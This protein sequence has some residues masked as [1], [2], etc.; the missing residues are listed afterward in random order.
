M[1]DINT[2]HTAPLDAGNLDR[3]LRALSMRLEENNAAPVE[4]VLCG[5]AA[6]ILSGM[7]ERVTRDVDIVALRDGSRLATPDP[8]PPELQKAAD[9]VAEDLG[10]SPQWLNNGPSSGDGG[11]FQMG[12]PEGFADR[13]HRRDYGRHL[14]VYFIDRRDQVH[15]K[16]YAAVDRGGYHIDDLR[17]LHPS[18]DELEAAAA[19][20]M[21]HD[22]SEGFRMLLKRLLGELGYEA[23]ACRI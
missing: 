19:W 20:A 15:F 11:L 6:L 9:E 4:L 16:L 10:L 13:L 2:T 12:L 1:A 21:T 8:L 18:V 7:A 22:V 5:G 17:A 3:T 23:L 14:N